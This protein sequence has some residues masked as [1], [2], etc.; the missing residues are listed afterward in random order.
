M[1]F[2]DL[3]YVRASLKDLLILSSSTFENHLDKLGSVLQHLQNKG[4]PIN[5]PKSTFA[6]DENDIHQQAFES[7]KMK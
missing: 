4:L 6:T 1:L 2:D 5:A 3:Q 7:I